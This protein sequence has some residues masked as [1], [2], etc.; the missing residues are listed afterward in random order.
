VTGIRRGTA[1]EIWVNG[2]LKNSAA[3][4]DLDLGKWV[5]CSIPHW[6]IS[7]GGGA[8]VAYWNGLIDELK[9]YTRALQQMRSQTEY[10]F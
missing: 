10:H 8:D 6:S 7:S 5:R 9:L 1:I 4:P 3:V 2:V